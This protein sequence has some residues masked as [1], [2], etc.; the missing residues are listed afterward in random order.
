MEKRH[1]SIKHIILPV[2]AVALIVIGCV[3]FW[4]MNT[5]KNTKDNEQVEILNNEIDVQGA[6]TSDAAGSTGDILSA[7]ELEVLFQNVYD[8]IHPIYTVRGYTTDAELLEE[9]LGRLPIYAEGMYGS[10][11]KLPA[12]YEEQYKTWRPADA[13]DWAIPMTEDQLNS[14]FEM[15]YDE[16]NPILINRGWTNEEEIITGEIKDIP[17]YLRDNFPNKVLPDDYADQ[18]RAWRLE[19]HPTQ[20]STP[21]NNS[22]PASQSKPSGQSTSGFNPVIVDDGTEGV[23]FDD[24]GMWKDPQD[25]SDP[26]INYDGYDEEYIRQLL[27]ESDIA[28]LCIHPMSAWNAAQRMGMTIEEYIA[29]EEEQPHGFLYG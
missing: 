16:V 3:L 23:S 27:A 20:A 1:L 21:S 24:P 9:E 4:H 13:G 18:Y 2:M 26:S 12:D 25:F 28:W 19:A 14:L 15:T 7:E 17:Y 29:W 8:K 11:K 10:K 5:E 22:S 6:A